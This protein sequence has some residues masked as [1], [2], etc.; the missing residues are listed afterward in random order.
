MSELNGFRVAVLATN[1]FEESE[2]TEP[3]NDAAAVSYAEI[4]CVPAVRSVA[5]K[6]WTPA[7]SA[8]KV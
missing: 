4:V 5:G 7:S 6:V 3:V 2:L 8:V 1:G